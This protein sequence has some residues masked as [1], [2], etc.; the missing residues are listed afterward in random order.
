[1]FFLELILKFLLFVELKSLQLFYYCFFG[2]LFTLTGSFF[3]CSV[4]AF[5]D[6]VCLGLFLQAHLL[7]L[8]S[9]LMQVF[10]KVLL[11]LACLD[12]IF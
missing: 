6:L 11:H 9:F 8:F 12:L 4:T 10:Y 7:H 1:M 2:K 3:N 5:G